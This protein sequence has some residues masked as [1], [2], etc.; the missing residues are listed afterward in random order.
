MKEADYKPFGDFLKRSLVMLDDYMPNYTDHERFAN[1]GVAFTGRTVVTYNRS[2]FGERYLQYLYRNDLGPE[3]LEFMRRTKTYDTVEGVISREFMPVARRLIR[4]ND[5]LYLQPF[6][7]SPS[8]VKVADKLGLQVF[9]DQI[10]V[11]DLNDKIVIKR[12]AEEE[13]VRI[14]GNHTANTRE[15]ISDIYHTL[16]VGG[17]PIVF[18]SSFDSGGQGNFIV[19]N[20]TELRHFLENSFEGREP[21][22]IEPLIYVKSTPCC[23]FFADPKGEVHYL[24]TNEQ[25]TKNQVVCIGSIFPGELPSPVQ[26]EI[27]ESSIRLAKRIAKT[28]Y[29]GPFGFDYLIDHNDQPFFLEAN[30]RVN[31]THCM[32]DMYNTLGAKCGLLSDFVTPVKFP[33]MDTILAQVEKKDRLTRKQKGVFPFFP[34]GK[35]GQLDA[36]AVIILGDEKEE[37]LRLR[38][39]YSKVFQ[40]K[41]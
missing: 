36:F 24:G 23:L 1:T 13:G 16:S 25:I 9:S 19:R 3:N 29:Y 38:E 18:K 39:K 5:L 21:F 15:E 35:N 34:M 27:Y 4:E 20:E 33:D 2:D 12:I 22:V 8:V 28:G 41:F 10:V 14:L 6:M 37:L 7:T 17:S 11:D 26:E 40:I 32:L 30:V 31:Y